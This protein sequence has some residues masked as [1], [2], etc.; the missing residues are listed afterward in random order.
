MLPVTPCISP[1]PDPASGLR[2]PLGQASAGRGPRACGAIRVSARNPAEVSRRPRRP[3]GARGVA[4]TAAAPSPTASASASSETRHIAAGVDTLKILERVRS[5]DDG[6]FPD[7]RP[8]MENTRASDQIH[9]RDRRR[10]VVARQGP[11]RRLDRRPARR[12][13]ATR[14]RLQKFDPYINVDPGTMSPYQHGEVYVTDDGAETDLDLGPLRALHQHDGDAQQ[15]L[16]HRQDLHVG[17]PEGAPRRLPRPHRA[18]DSAH[19]Q[20]DQGLHPRRPAATSTSCSSRSAARS[21]TSRA[22]R[23]SRRSASSARTSA[24]RTRSTST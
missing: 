12:A 14:S 5:D 2:R 23:S 18:G 13:T 4:R 22:C 10:G 6:L 15:Q 1:R 7:L 20:R 16:D 8:S 21:A 9:L 11:G 19:H 17:D 3:A 24:A